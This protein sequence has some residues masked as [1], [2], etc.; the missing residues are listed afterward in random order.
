[1]A[2]TSD[3]SFKAALRRGELQFG[4]W[5]A[6]AE[7]NSAEVCA[8]AGFDWLLIDGEHGPYDLRTMLS[9]L[10]AVAP[11]PAHPVVRIPNHDASLIKQVL[12]IGATTLMVPMV[13]TVEQARELVHATR[14]PPE[15]IRGVG[16]TLARASRWGDRT[17]YLATAN[18]RQCLL[19]QV[20][21]ASAVERA[22]AIASM[23]GVDGVFVGPVDLAASMG[24][25]GRPD[26]PEVVSAV[27]AAIEAI[28]RAGKAPGIYCPDEVLA[29]RYAERGARFIA[30]GADSM[31]LGRGARALAARVRG[32]D[33][34]A[35]APST[36][37][38]RGLNDIG[39]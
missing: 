35:V 21:S 18:E 14:Y 36:G 27:D 23:D 3:N 17:D 13:E 19:L 5:L 26:H 9:V 32:A 15:G 20:E 1:V 38:T 7:P 28:L 8:T 2:I 4:L 30:V 34:E 39:K 31:L 10:R 6:L 16:S 29:R 22:E 24:H 25:L 37:I 11:Y 12:D 33:P